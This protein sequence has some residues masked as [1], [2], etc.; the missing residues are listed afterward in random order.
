[1]PPIRK[2]VKTFKEDFICDTC[3]EGVVKYTGVSFPMFPPQYQHKC[4]VC[5]KVHNFNLIY[6]RIIQEEVESGGE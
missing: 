5:D 1:M 6:P 4:V 2:E 3:K